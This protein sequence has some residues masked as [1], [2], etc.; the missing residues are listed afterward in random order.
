MTKQVT[1]IL[2]AGAIVILYLATRRQESEDSRFTAV[3]GIRG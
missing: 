3:A 1:L 2:M